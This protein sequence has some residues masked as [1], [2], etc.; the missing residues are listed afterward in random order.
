MQAALSS[1]HCKLTPTDNIWRSP[2]SYT[3]T[4]CRT[5]PTSGT[6]GSEVLPISCLFKTFLLLQRNLP[7]SLLPFSNLRKSPIILFSFVL[8]HLHLAINIVHRVWDL[9][10]RPTE[11][12]INC[13]I[14][15]KSFGPS[16]VSV[17][18][19]KQCGLY[20]RHY[21]LSSLVQAFC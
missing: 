14:Q 9:I 19:S 18:A 20:T 5:T 1:L 11:F 21:F 12:E 15:L 3:W 16:G 7:N 8:S 4:T 6:K 2:S 17:P 13:S 10:F